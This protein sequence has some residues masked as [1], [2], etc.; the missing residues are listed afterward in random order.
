MSFIVV[1]MF[2]VSKETTTI[3]TREEG[4]HPLA[5]VIGE[6]KTVDATP[7]KTA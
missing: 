7:T 1:P 2:L 5:V 6:F 3:V 4:P